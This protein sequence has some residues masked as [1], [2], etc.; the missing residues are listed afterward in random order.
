MQANNANIFFVIFCAFVMSACESFDTKNHSLS[1][2]TA[3]NN[4]TSVKQIAKKDPIKRFDF[5][6]KDSSGKIFYLDKYHSKTD[7]DTDKK[8]E[9]YNLKEVLKTDLGIDFKTKTYN[10]YF[11]IAYRC[12]DAQ[13]NA[14]EYVS[15]VFF[16]DTYSKYFL[17]EPPHPFSIVYFA[18]KEEFEKHTKTTAYGFYRPSEKTL[19]TYTGSGEGTLWHE[20]MHAFMYANIEHDT[21]Q[22]FSEGFA[23]FY[24]MGAIQQNKFIE[25][26]TNWRLP[27][28]QAM[29]KKEKN[30]PLNLFLAEED[31]SEDNA[32][33][34]ARFLFCYLWVYDKIIPFSKSYMYDLSAKY[35]GKQLALKSIEKI[36][37]LV[38]KP[39]AEIEKEYNSMAFKYQKYQKLS[40]KI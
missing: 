29:L 20:L 24:E 4:T 30:M 26:Y 10:K 17:Y 8:E 40:V 33:A 38:G 21:Q 9:L 34:K 28:L 7:F 32:Y 3:T 19:Y 2:Q 39:F 37:E 12:T 23:S 5:P 35:K 1:T 6:K 22:W 31:M 27:L 36:E 14:L 11:N 15:S 13:A 18:T 25:G 16:R